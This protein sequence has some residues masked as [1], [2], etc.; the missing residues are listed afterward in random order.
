MND[1]Q[2]CFDFFDGLGIDHTTVPHPELK[3]A[4]EAIAYAQ[5][6]WEFP[7]KNFFTYDKKKNFYLIS[8]HLA[9]PALD[10][11]ALGDQIG[12]R[13]RLSFAKDDSLAKKLKVRPGSVSPFAIMYDNEC[14]ITVVLDNGLKNA[15]TISAHPLDNTMTTT[16]SV[17]DLEKIYNQTG[18]NPLWIDIPVR[19]VG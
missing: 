9:M 14:D 15:K 18:H 16:I 5:G 7:V 19:D 8:V 1:H 2:A 12:A 3:T 10:L 6:R 17:V 4:Q 11:K 13:G